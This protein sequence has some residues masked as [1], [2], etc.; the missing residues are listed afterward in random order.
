MDVG[1]NKTTTN[2]KDN[3]NV[4][5]ASVIAISS[6]SHCEKLATV[7]SL[8]KNT[9]NWLWSPRHKRTHLRTVF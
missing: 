4:N 3:N 9:G 6:D 7:G 8:Q 2:D 1:D 5:G